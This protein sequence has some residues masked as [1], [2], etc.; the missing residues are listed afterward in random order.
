MLPWRLRFFI[1]FFASLRREFV[2]F[3]S[4]FCSGVSYFFSFP[5]GASSSDTLFEEVVTQHYFV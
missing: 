4:R 5:S 2:G 3:F 1:L